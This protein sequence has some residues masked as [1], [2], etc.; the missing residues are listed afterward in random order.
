M[1]S[2]DEGA[3]LKEEE[4][5]LGLV[6]QAA[7]EENRRWTSTAITVEIKLIG[8]RP[9]GLTPADSPIVQT[10]RRSISSVLKDAKINL[11]GGSTDSNVAMSLGVPAVTISGGG[12]GGNQHSRSEWY[13]PANAYVGPQN[14]LLT[15]LTLVGIKGVSEPV[16]TPHR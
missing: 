10:A 2:N 11:T 16:L 9:A 4:Q 7:E 1:R 13:K 5:I 12:E 6:K 3:L 15:L 8:D 14:A